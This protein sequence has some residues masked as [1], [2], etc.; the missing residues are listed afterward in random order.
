VE[1][2]VTNKNL[3]Q[4]EIE[5]RLNSGE[6]CYYLVQKLIFSRLLFRK[7]NIRIQDC[8]FGRG[9]VRVRIFVSDT[10]GGT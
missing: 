9:S 3:V 1:T 6:A 10:K 4:E 8:N 7:L 5:R 2:R